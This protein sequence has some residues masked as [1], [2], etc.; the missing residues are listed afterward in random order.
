MGNVIRA[1]DWPE[2]GGKTAA[3]S[4]GSNGGTGISGCR[5]AQRT[6]EGHGLARLRVVVEG[7]T[8]GNAEGEDDCRDGDPDPPPRDLFAPPPA[9]TLES[10][11]WTKCHG[12]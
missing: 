8:E 5:D 10:L 2:I 1:A 9:A 12:A 6:L 11:Y 4:L 3:R 7:L